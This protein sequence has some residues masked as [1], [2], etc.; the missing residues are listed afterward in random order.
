MHACRR[1]R[2]QRDLLEGAFASL[3]LSEVA[4]HTS[5]FALD[6]RPPWVRKEVELPGVRL[7]RRDHPP[8]DRGAP[9][10]ATQSTQSGVLVRARSDAIVSMIA[11]R[12]AGGCSNREPRGA[13]NTQLHCSARAGEAAL[14]I[15]FDPDESHN[16]GFAT[17]RMPIQ[18]V[19]SRDAALHRASGRPNPDQLERTSFRRRVCG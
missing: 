1:R 4:G 11:V 5:S 15:P 12:V 14:A 18:C 10:G 6:P 16:G 17:E 2:H 13:T 3:R 8:A 19:R 9:I 7:H